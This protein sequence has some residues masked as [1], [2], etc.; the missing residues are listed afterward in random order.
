[1]KQQNLD[2]SDLLAM[3]WLLLAMKFQTQ[4]TNNLYLYFCRP[5]CP[6]LYRQNGVHEFGIRHTQVLSNIEKLHTFLAPLFT[7]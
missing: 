7:D 6:R 5:H 3:H 1:M 4:L 2:I